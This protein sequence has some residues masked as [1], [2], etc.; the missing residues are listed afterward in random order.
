MASP[1]A[2]LAFER[3]PSPLS[4]LA[5]QVKEEQEEEDGEGKSTSRE[6]KTRRRRGMRERKWSS[7][8]HF[9]WVCLWITCAMISGPGGKSRRS[10]RWR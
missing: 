10:K 5:R 7:G 4:S 2:S 9:R 1:V 6:G 3:C 8:A